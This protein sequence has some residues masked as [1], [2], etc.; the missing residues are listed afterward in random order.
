MLLCIEDVRGLSRFLLLM[1]YFL[2]LLRLS[3]CTLD[4]KQLNPGVTCRQ[5]NTG[6]ERERAIDDGQTK[7]K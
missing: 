2:L 6:G 1:L 4:A 7:R 3:K 5:T